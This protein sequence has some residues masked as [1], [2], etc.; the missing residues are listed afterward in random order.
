[1]DQ[2]KSSILA[3][4]KTLHRKRE[5]L[6]I[7]AAKRN[8]P[9]LLK[10]AFQ[11]K[12]FLGWKGALNAAGISYDDINTEIEDY[13][14]CEICGKDFEVLPMHLIH[15]HEMSGGD[16][17]EAYPGLNLT[18]ELVR[19]KI[20]PINRGMKLFPHW[21]PAWSAE[22]TLDRLAEC[23]IR[24]FPMNYSWMAGKEKALATQALR[25][26]ET[27]DKALLKIGLDPKTI[28]CAEP[29]Q[30]WDKNTIIEALQ[31]RRQCGLA[32]DYTTLRKH[33][34][35]HALV[36]AMIR[37]FA[38]FNSA[39]QAAGIDPQSEQL[40]LAKYGSDQ[41]SEIIQA[42]KED[43]TLPWNGRQEA[44]KK[45]KARYDRIVRNCDVFTSWKNV[46]LAAGVSLNIFTTYPDKDA[47]IDAINSRLAS[48]LPVDSKSLHRGN[49]T[50][51]R[52]VVKYFT[53]FNNMRK[54]FGLPV[55][56]PSS[57]A[58]LIP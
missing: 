51:Y 32:S 22:Y 54:H 44:F 43:A 5:P 16:Y 19:S 53:N 52:E 40:R 15:H 20:S 12:P 29:A 37:Y 35:N 10:A 27:W 57:K 46:F 18:S 41:I 4:I 34:K 48:G 3:A 38:D 23:K 21:E 2:L 39:L 13:I 36:N 1:M 49:R 47:V 9:E 42:V 55:V 26:F 56:A 33:E 14:V 50:L 31:R 25:V 30:T 58:E 17:K 11:I 24:K 7:S 8:H 28:R 6:N 45:T